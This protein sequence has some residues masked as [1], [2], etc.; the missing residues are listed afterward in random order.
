M[1]A[2]GD[3]AGTVWGV[4][5]GVN[6]NEAD[7]AGATPN[8]YPVPSTSTG[9]YY[10]VSQ[11]PLQGLRI[12]TNDSAGNNYCAV[13]TATSGLIP[14]TSFNTSCWS[15]TLGTY[16]IGPPT[17]SRNISFVVPAIVSGV[18]ETFNFC[19]DALQYQ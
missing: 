8:T 6:L 18:A 16:M 7:V 5:V 19:V 9:I 2:A 15:P 3:T 10:Q 17:A 12:Q 1:T 13:L 4:L 14:W 11:R